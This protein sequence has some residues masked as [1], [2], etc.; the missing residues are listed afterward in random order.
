[1]DSATL[2]HM[3]VTVIGI[4]V[5]FVMGW[6]MCRKNTE[7]KLNILAESMHDLIKENQHLIAHVRKIQENFIP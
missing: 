3:F 1:M 7:I 5:G 4:Q 2:V 6:Y